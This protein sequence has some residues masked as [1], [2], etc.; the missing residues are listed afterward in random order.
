MELHTVKDVVVPIV[1]GALSL[2]LFLLLAS[3]VPPRLVISPHI[4]KMPPSGCIRPAVGYEVKVVN[5]SRCP[6]TEVRARLALLRE[7]S[8]P[9]GLSPIS[10]AHPAGG[11][12]W[13][14]H[15]SKKSTLPFLYL[16]RTA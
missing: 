5:R 11:E 14:A 4:A 9:D 15:L 1:I 8:V 7:F 12:G 3:R 16:P 2:V 10:G 13:S 6:A